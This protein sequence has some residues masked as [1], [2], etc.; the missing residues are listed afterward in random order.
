M[1]IPARSKLQ[2]ADFD[3]VI[4]SGTIVDGSGGPSYVADLAIRDGKIVRIGRIAERGVEEIDATGQIVTPGF[5]DIHTHYDG[6]VTWET[7]LS[8]SSNHGVTTVLTGNCG[9]GFAPC[10]STQ[11]DTLVKVMEGVED[12]PEIVMTEGIPWNWETFPEYL[13]TLKA[14]RYDIDF[15]TQVPHSAIR[16]YVMNDGDG[17]PDAAQ[18]RQMTEIVRDAIRAGA[19][20]VSS[21]QHAGHRTVEGDLAP[22]VKAAT[23]ELF[24][25]AE[26]LKEADGGVFQVIT[27]GYSAKSDAAK[28]MALIRRIAEIS[29]R[30]VSYSLLQK[31]HC[32]DLPEAML[33]LN[34]HAQADGL[35]I[36]AQVFPRPVGLM[37]GLGL[38][39]HPF[40]FRPSYEAIHALPLDQR[41]AAM[42]DPARR[43]AILSETPAH[44][45]PVFANIVKD[46]EDSFVLGDP[47]NYEPTPDQSIRAQ[48]RRTGT[49]PA[50]L[51]YDLLL[52]CD[53]TAILLAPSSN[54]SEGDL[55]AVRRMMVDD[56][57]LL[58]LGDGGA[59]YGMICD[60]SY[61][62]TVL[63]YWTRDRPEGR[64][65]LEWAVNK[66]SR[67]NALAIGLTDRGLLAEGMKADI[68]VID[69]ANLTLHA[70]H[71]VHD[72]P[73]GGRRLV[74]SADGYTATLV[75]GVITYRDGQPTGALPGRLLRSGDYA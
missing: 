73:A 34:R 11:R 7:R 20:G 56:N 28:Q 67:R 63:S 15:A 30:P 36:R 14:R 23:D 5:V 65:S 39:F 53:G 61:P 58:A 10:R 49:P 74:Q 1:S 33:A 22:S 57:T 52:E 16:V 55:E 37:F 47:P 25:L 26:G 62:T 41:V 21:S 44:P 48:A 72:L 17:P 68:N 51:V 32:V 13:D 43:Q 75:N 64:V 6:Q 29:G 69:Y 4:R 50:E 8:P 59:H 70:P 40:R 2:A 12:I 19:F 24:A 27:D 66:L 71:P 18:L 9:V 60:S 31:D 35:P 54:Y 42:R 3:V 38:S 45:N 46:F